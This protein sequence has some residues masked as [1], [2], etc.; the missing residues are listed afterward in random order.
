MT[1]QLII[2]QK[3]TSQR[4]I[5][6]LCSI[7]I[8]YPCHNLAI[9]CTRVFFPSSKCTHCRLFLC[10]QKETRSICCP[11]F[12]SCKTLTK[13]KVGHAVNNL[14]F[15]SSYSPKWSARL[16][17][18]TCTTWTYVHYLSKISEILEY[19]FTVLDITEQQQK[20]KNF[21]CELF[22]ARKS[23]AA[24]IPPTQ[25]SPVLESYF[26]GYLRKVLTFLWASILIT[27]L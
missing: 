5:T 15:F 16:T 2:M 11:Q 9:N 4:F 27:A 24:T 8:F 17:F 20:L 21:N 18:Q 6:Y 14:K 13:R 7:H 22:L 1:L 3:Q 26:L 23:D 19:Y 12:S 10:T 25:W